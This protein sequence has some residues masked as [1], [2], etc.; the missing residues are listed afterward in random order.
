MTLSCLFSLKLVCDMV[1]MLT[2]FI[3]G[4]MACRCIKLIVKHVDM[5]TGSAFNE[6]IH[7]DGLEMTATPANGNCLFFALASQLN[8]YGFNTTYSAV[9]CQLVEFLRQF[10][11]NPKVCSFPWLLSDS[12]VSS[13]LSQCGSGTMY[14]GKVCYLRLPCLLLHLH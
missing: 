3:V 5:F 10:Q 7:E 8:L 9:R 2:Y 14:Q 4:S 13:S 1:E 12:S 6:Q 11:S